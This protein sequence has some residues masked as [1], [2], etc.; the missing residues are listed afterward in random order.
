MSW[1]LGSLVALMQQ[2]IIMIH[3]WASWLASY[4]R[5]RTYNLNVVRPMLYDIYFATQVAQTRTQP[6]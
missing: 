2:P 3:Y 1:S 4:I 5:I 6:T